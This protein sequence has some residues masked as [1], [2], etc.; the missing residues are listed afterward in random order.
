MLAC[1]NDSNFVFAGLLILRQPALVSSHCHWQPA[2]LKKAARRGRFAMYAP[3]RERRKHGRK[4]V[5]VD[6][7]ERILPVR[8]LGARLVVSFATY[9]NLL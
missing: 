9:P 7:V 8:S 6:E 2:V 1:K 5:F 4:I 3:L